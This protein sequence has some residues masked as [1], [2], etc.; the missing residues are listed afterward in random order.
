MNEWLIK[1]R[2]IKREWIYLT[3]A[4]LVAL[5]LFVKLPL[6]FFVGPQAKGLYEAVESLPPDKVV[7]LAMDWGPA[8]KG[9]SMW[10]AQAVIEHLLKKK[11]PFIITGYDILGPQL[12]EELADELAKKYKAKY[13]DDWVNVGFITGGLAFLLRMSKN[14]KEA[15]KEDSIKHKPLDS[16]SVSRKVRDIHDIGLI[17]NVTG[18]GSYGDWIIIQTTYKVPLAVACTAVITPDLYPFLDS[19]Q[20]IGM[21]SGLKGAAEY[22]M[23]IK[24]SHRSA[25]LR[26][27]ISQSMAHILI[28]LL[29][30]LGNIG[31]YLERRMRTN[32]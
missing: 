21:L 1:L 24:G 18:S 3:L 20:L 29:I 4:I 26:M 6:P 8:T 2:S 9:E 32:A 27:M 15:F 11:K 25:T 19:K 14:F 7:L 10:Q 31:L 5:P 16:Y 23:L 13:G 22:E 30:V 12:S 28:I 17:I